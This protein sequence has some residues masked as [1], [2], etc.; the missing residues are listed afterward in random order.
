MVIINK[1]TI[2]L[3]FLIFIS[4]ILTGCW[5]KRELNELAIVTAAGIDKTD[6]GYEVS[7]QIINPSEIAPEN[8]SGK[9]PVITYHATGESV[10]EAIRKLDTLTPRKAYFAHL[11]ILV[12]GDSLASN[13]INQ[14]ID[15]FARDP[16]TRDDFSVIVSS[17]SP[18]KEVISVLT[19][20]EKIPAKKILNS[21][22]ASEK[23]LGTTLSVD[24]DQI[25][26]NFGRAGS[27]Y[28]LPTI[29]IIG[30]KDVDVE[31]ENVEKISTPTILK[32]SGLA[33]FKQDKLIGILSE[34]QS[35]TFNYIDNNVKSTLEIISCPD[36][37]GRLTT[38]ITSSIAKVTG[39]FKN[40]KPKINIRL[41]LTQNVGQVIKCNIDLSDNKTIEYINTNTEE[42]V[43]MQIEETLETIQQY[44]HTDIFGFGDVLHREDPKEWGVI[45]ENWSNMFTEL[46]VTVE[47]HVITQSVGAIDKNKNKGEVIKV[48]K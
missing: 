44:Y 22:R 48:Y 27:S 9:S 31:N 32:Y 35:K 34:K 36:K 46:P 45:K 47:V 39:E 10:F 21:L 14:S 19:P 3:I 15:L 11:N 23:A 13:G 40:G 38:E 25:L 4:I 24:I 20:L 12:I 6:E 8:T 16:E 17:S 41:D 30:E 28:I 2:K 29:E 18:A 37:I 7:V 26:Q 42:S 1:T 33:I 5:S 43:K